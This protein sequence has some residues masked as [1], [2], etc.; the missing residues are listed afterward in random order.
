MPKPEKSK[1][2]NPQAKKSVEEVAPEIVEEEAVVIRRKSPHV[3]IQGEWQDTL[4]YKD[5]TQKVVRGIIKP[6]QIQNQF[7]VLLASLCRGESGYDRIAYMGIGRGDVAWDSGA[8]SQPYSQT[9]LEDEFF[10]KAIPQAD[11]VFVDKDTNVPTGGTPSSKIEI[12]VTL[13]TSEAN[14]VLREFGLFG[15]TATASVDTGEIVNW[16]A[17]DRI[18]KDN[19]L[20]IERI[21]RIEFVTR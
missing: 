2:K 16:I 15:G 14:D 18:D 7:A 1:S 21:V 3:Q 19:T 8:P 13:A 12:T 10:R 17:H 5:G 9:T 6:N 4:K 20:E 11:I